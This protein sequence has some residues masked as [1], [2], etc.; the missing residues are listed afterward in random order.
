MA[1]LK[2]AGIAQAF[3][4]VTV[5]S[6]LNG[7]IES[8]EK[9]G[10]VGPNG[11]GKTTLLLLIAGI[12]EPYQGT[13]THSDGVQIG[14]LRQEAVDAFA[15]KQNT[16]Y[17][18]M[19]TVFAGMSAREARLREL[20]EL[21]ATDYSEA[22][23]EEYSAIQ[24]EFDRL[25]GY[26]YEVRIKQTLSGLGFTEAHYQTPLLHLSGGQKTRALLCRLLLEQPHLLIL[27]EPT[28]HLDTHAVEWL[29][30]TLRNWQGALLVASHDR[31]FLDSV[32]GT[33]WEMSRGGME[34]FKGNYSAYL[35]QRDARW[36]YQEKLYQT[37]KDRLRAELDYIK[38]NIA[39]SSTNP[40]AVGK[41]R[42]LSRDLVAIEEMGLVAY[43][44]SKN[45]SSTGVGS[46]R[47]LT[48]AEAEAA[49]HNFKSPNVRP[50]KLAMR[51]KTTTR[52]GN[53]VLRGTKLKIGY[54]G[55]TL[56]STEQLMLER[57]DCAALI[58]GNGAGKTT[59]LKTVLKELP[60]LSGTLT[61]GMGVKV[62]YFAQA[63]NQLDPEKSVLDELL[64]HKQMQISDA[65]KHL[66]QYLF[67][68]EDVFKLVG[69]LSGG[70]RGRL[71]LAILAT[72]GANFML[73][74]EPTNH[75]DIPAQE[76]IQEV[77]N[78]FEG[79]ILLV[80]HD[81]YLVSQLATQIWH[82]ENGEL[83]VFE[84]SYEEYLAKRETERLAA[85]A[86]AAAA[87]Q[88]TR[89]ALRNAKKPDSRQVQ[90]LETQIA[91]QEKAL[92][93]LSESLNRP[94]NAPDEILR[95]SQEYAAVQAQLD[96]LIQQWEGLAEVS[97]A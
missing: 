77:F 33:I 52:S 91:A 65:R 31:Y 43:K 56:F 28:N 87:K 4:A 2:L 50:P 92:A 12:T 16:L 55:R 34:I 20:E 84:G 66:A 62:G 47:P 38:A 74:D 96:A 63:H 57:G 81:R 80:S 23:M 1:I 61:L 46:I 11:I 67:R 29:E 71:A 72:H 89:E 83:I 69:K 59:F 90:Q 75:L 22:V 6:G 36:E 54:P 68:G 85:K 13:I 21:M 14:Y 60:P 3:G 37:E 51:L 86:R 95:L 79:T 30:S 93:S 97:M 7:A 49:L 94:N 35:K 32:V 10:L 8:H 44:A 27:D 45:W 70:E 15:L 53:T 76:A 25:G 73:L 40:Q 26:D 42:L 88:A 9:V 48:V 41:L 82:V 5:F 39:R 24:E 18:E 19:L 58:G 17:D 78:L 64:V